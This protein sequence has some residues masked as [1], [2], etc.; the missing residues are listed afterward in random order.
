MTKARSIAN[1]LSTANGKIAGTNLDVS[2][3]NISDTGTEGTKVASGTTAQRGST[4]GQFRFNSTTGKFE[5]KNAN[6]FVTLEVT[7]TVTS[8]DVTEVDS[9][10]GGNQTFVITGTN[11][12]TGDIASFVGND[13]TTVTASTTTINS[14]T[15]ITAVAPK[16]SFASAKEPYD[17]KIASTGG[18]QG[19]LL[20]QINVD[21]APVWSTSAGSLGEIGE[22]AT[23]NHFTLSATDPDGDTVTYAETGGSNITG[24]GLSLSSGGVISGNPTDVSSNTTVSFDVRATANSKNTDRSFSLIVKDSFAWDVLGGISSSGGNAMNSA[25]SYMQVFFD[26]ADTRSYSGSGTNI[27]NMA[28]ALGSDNQKSG[29]QTWS[30]TNLTTGGSGNGKYFINSSSGATHYIRAPGNPTNQWSNGSNDQLAFCGWWYLKS[31]IDSTGELWI[32]NDGDW[33]PN[34]QVGIRIQSGNLRTL[35]GSSNNVQE[36]LPSGSGYTNNWWFFC[37]YMGARGGYYSGLASNNATNLTDIVTGGHSYNTGTDTPQPFTIGARP[38]SLS[39][40]NPSNTRMGFQAVWGAN[41]DAFLNSSGS[42]ANT[43]GKA[44]FEQ[45]FD[46]TKGFYS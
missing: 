37:A 17:V 44:I 22:N 24:A 11:F 2:F 20:N 25:A 15:Q 16:A 34:G 41:D 13:G 46:Q 23:G 28:W 31:D 12:S 21:S 9:Q 8:V 6:S 27:T 26:P 32:M 29:G 4:A 14:S 42:Y 30:M 43:D 1:L 33:G 45:I 19:S 7:P 5:G 10:A 3:E 39:T 36:A 18:L 38:D 35:R 40:Y